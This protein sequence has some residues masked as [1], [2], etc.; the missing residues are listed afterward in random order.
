MDDLER[1][2][3]K[4]ARRIAQE[5]WRKVRRKIQRELRELHDYEED[6]D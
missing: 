5:E 6:D 3:E 4:V 2:I 1:F